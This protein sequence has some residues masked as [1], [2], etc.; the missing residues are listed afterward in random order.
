MKYQVFLLFLT[1]LFRVPG[2]AQDE[3][4]KDQ[5]TE[6]GS[7][8][9][10]EEFNEALPLYLK[11]KRTHPENYNL[12]Y[13]IGRCYLFIPYQKNKAISYLEEAVNHI[14]SKYRGKSLKEQFAPVDALFYLG[15]AYHI[16]NE[17]D[18]A[19]KTYTK[20]LEILDDNKYDSQ[21]VQHYI[22][23]CHFAKKAMKNKKN[24]TFTNLG[25]QINNRFS[26]TNPV[27][28]GDGN[29]L[30]Y[31]SKLQFYDAVFFCTR[32]G[33]GWSNPR[34]II[35]ELKVDDKIY[36]TSL[37]FDGSE[38]Y[39]YKLDGYDG[40][41][42]VANYESGRWTEPVKLNG[43]INTR[44][45]ESHA[46]ISK[47]GNTLYFSS[48]RPGGYGELDI[49]Y[50]KRTTG[51]NW[52]EP[53]NIGNVIN[54]DQN[55]DTPFITGDGQRLY[56]SSLGHRAMGGYDLFFS[57]KMPDGTWNQP[58]NMGHPL[59]TTDDELFFHPSDNGNTGYFSILRQDGYG[60]HD[61]YR[62]NM[63]VQRE[64]PDILVKINLDQAFD[65]DLH[66]RFL[67]GPGNEMVNNET[68]D[69][70]AN[71]I[72]AELQPGAYK[73][74]ITGENVKTS[75]TSF[76][77]TNANENKV[78]EL[79]L[80]LEGKRKKKLSSF[81]K[82]DEEKQIPTKVTT[83]IK[84]DTIEKT[85]PPANTQVSNI[86]LVIL[87][88][89]MEI[90]SQ[91]ELDTA[92][93]S[94]KHDNPGIQ[95]VD[96]IYNQLLFM[97]EDHGFTTADVDL[98]MERYLLSLMRY[99]E[100]EQIKSILQERVNLESGHQGA[101]T[102]LSDF[103]NLLYALARIILNHNI[104]LPAVEAAMNQLYSKIS[105]IR[106]PLPSE[107]TDLAVFEWLEKVFSNRNTFTSETKARVAA[108]SLFEKIF[109]SVYIQG[110]N[111]IAEG[112]IRLFFSNLD[113]RS[114][115]N[116]LHLKDQLVEGIKTNEAT[117]NGLI[118]VMLQ[119][120]KELNTI[121][122]TERLDSLAI[123]QETRPKNTKSILLFV[124]GGIV[125]IFVILFTIRRKRKSSTK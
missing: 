53:V 68:I 62:V 59:N 8:F 74:I 114:I 95:S 48:N 71:E 83:E 93:Y 73:V 90:S 112:K 98:T 16:N 96:D 31:T 100:K 89:L 13:K 55:D 60:L 28:S 46:A 26:Q 9:L 24:V 5:F 45:W 80:S 41:I 37:S 92:L 113:K 105:T 86:L 104:P 25:N 91:K 61:L 88:D 109:V 15:R 120:N 22:E 6:A 121:Y 101:G 107:R 82:K 75:E 69:A 43:F 115:N 116:M 70:G 58:V 110:L 30:V 66:A 40:N 4:D 54:T 84:T 50:S 67:S 21:L 35:P 29:M 72:S 33:D 122:S 65:E 85:F 76:T 124:S 32:H 17:L 20:F 49:Y 108:M 19:I 34:N 106:G 64:Q 52:Q 7:Y 94:L 63:D 1:I 23:S 118:R 99:N 57:E 56:F 87:N 47:D 11:L 78:H 10:Y 38:L 27:V 3:S 111:E 81:L 44:Y 119:A 117:Y 51:N 42:Y 2:F 79:T 125:L 103:N 12:D 36:P 14:S 77:V 123:E 39:L 102:L 97:T 18:K